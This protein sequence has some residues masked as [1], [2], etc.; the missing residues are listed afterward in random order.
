LLSLAIGAHFLGGA[1]EDRLES[2]AGLMLL[3][4]GLTYAVYS[5][6]RHS[7]CHG[8]EHHGPRPDRKKAPFLFLFSLGLSPCVA[9][10]P[11][12]AAATTR[13]SA[14]VLMAMFAFAA[15]V[16]AALV[17]ATLLVSRGLIKLDHPIFE[18]HGDVITG[19]A[20]A[21]MGAIFYFFPL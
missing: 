3:A 16:V 14:S 17:G 13:G 7:H 11:V 1:S 9:V 12:F 15:G 8:H 5:Y 21:A 6:R 2:Y 10:L 19:L 18:H 20:V 4:F